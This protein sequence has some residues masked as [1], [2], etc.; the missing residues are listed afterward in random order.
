MRETNVVATR[1]WQGK[2][3]KL[4]FIM[5]GFLMM[6][7]S[8]PVHQIASTADF[9]STQKTRLQS[10]VAPT[11]LPF[12][13]RTTDRDDENLVR[14][15]GWQTQ[16]HGNKVTP[17][18]EKVF[19][20]NR[21]SRM[22][23]FITADRWR[24]ML[25]DMTELDGEFGSYTRS[26]DQ[27]P[28]YS[29][30]PVWTE[31]TLKFEQHRWTHVGVRFKGSL[32]LRGAWRSGSLKLPFKLDFDEFEERY[33]EI[34]NQRF[35]G[36]KQL[37]LD[38]NFRDDS[39]MR[40][41]LASRLF[42]AVDVP[43]AQTAFYELYVDYGEGL[44]YLGLYTLVEVVDD[45]AVKRI[46]GHDNGNIYEAEGQAAS[47]SSDALPTLSASFDR[48]NNRKTA[49]WRDI[50]T[51]HAVLHSS[52][53]L[54]TANKWRADLEALFN[55]DSFL[56]WLA[57]NTLIQNRDSYGKRAQN[58]YLYSNPETG[59]LEWI[60]WDHDAALRENDSTLSLSLTEVDERWPL[61][62]FLIDDPI[63]QTRYHAFVA[64][65][66]QEIFHPEVMAPEYTSL[67]HQLEPYAT[68]EVRGDLFATAVKELITHNAS[69]YQA[70][71]AY[72]ANP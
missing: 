44:T 18:Y 56:K 23:L 12:S 43:V 70:S 35:F 16:T 66:A 14:P 32:S 53:R 40:E 65:F 7:C 54:T 17:N 41:A 33:P 47:L 50:E 42:A 67:Y 25:N 8:P 15:R 30:H 13:V 31:A 72:I 52:T 55:V 57:L 1:N 24:A 36:F 48:E 2:C 20:D 22:E 39:F 21:V 5:A 71:Q 59:R 69:R 27:L 64:Q 60:T 4:L 9:E 49:D 63:Y 6:T 37:T 34:D 19:P 29:R 51:L 26:P 46:F 68:R 58:Y 61:I 10:P 45:T 28:D 38:N 62:R 11:K 3:P